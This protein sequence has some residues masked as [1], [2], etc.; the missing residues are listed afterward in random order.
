MTTS[1]KSTTKNKST[2]SM[3]KKAAMQADAKA[4]VAKLAAMEAEHQKNQRGYRNLFIASLFLNLMFIVA[5]YA[6]LEFQ[7]H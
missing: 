2:A 6:I 4:K 5:I 3:A 7:N 1:G